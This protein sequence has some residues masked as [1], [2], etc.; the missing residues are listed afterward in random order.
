MVKEV[1]YRLIKKL[2]NIEVRFY[3]SLIVAKV[4]GYSNAGFNI[5][6]EHISGNNRTK[7]NL[8][9]TAPVIAN[10]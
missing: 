2:N 6:F 8:E 5:L 4:E 1:K 7:T 9:M 3:N 10:L